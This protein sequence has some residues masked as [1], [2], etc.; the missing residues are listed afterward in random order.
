M[1]HAH[2]LYMNTQ[3]HAADESSSIQSFSWWPRSRAGRIV[4]TLLLA[5]TFWQAQ[6]G[7][8][9]HL[10]ATVFGYFFMTAL[11]YAWYWLSNSP[12]PSAIRIWWKTPGVVAAGVCIVLIVIFRPSNDTTQPGSN[13]NTLS[14]EEKL[15]EQL[16]ASFSTNKQ[17]LFEA[18]HPLGTANSVKV[19]DVAIR[20]K[21][22]HLHQSEKD[23]EQFTVRFTVYWKGPVQSDGFTKATQTYDAE[24]ERWIGG[25]VLNTNGITKADTFY[26]GGYVAGSLFREWLQN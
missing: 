3:D 24:S 20:W 17:A 22:G 10:Y 9:P 2:H 13:V 1:S 16:Q 21:E 19:H 5:S 7:V 18:L 26:V 4:Q 15:M 6:P 8:Y 23:V 25:N 14:V 11:R 12:Q